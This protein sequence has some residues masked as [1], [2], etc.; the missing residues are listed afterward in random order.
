[1][2]CIHRQRPKHSSGDQD[3]V[4]FVP[5]GLGFGEV[6][7]HHDRGS[8]VDGIGPQVG[9]LE[10]TAPHILD[11]IPRR[12]GKIGLNPDIVGRGTDQR[13]LQ[14]GMSVSNPF[15]AADIEKR[16]GAAVQ[17]G[18]IGKDE[19]VHNAVPTNP[20]PVTLKEWSQE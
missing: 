3:L 15:A 4:E 12:H 20:L 14:A 5:K 16:E 18:R 13:L 6:F 17:T 10:K 2:A 1:M 7:E 19:V 9:L 11:V 8:H